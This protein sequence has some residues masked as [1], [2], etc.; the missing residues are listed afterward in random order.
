MI[1]TSFNTQRDK[2]RCCRRKS[3]SLDQNSNSN[4]SSIHSFIHSLHLQAGDLTSQV[5]RKVPKSKTET[6]HDLLHCGHTSTPPSVAWFLSICPKLLK[7]LRETA[8]PSV[9]E[10]VVPHC[11]QMD[12]DEAD[13][14]FLLTHLEG[15]VGDVYPH[16]DTRTA[17]LMVF[18]VH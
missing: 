2:H 10:E 14:D 5:P 11:T 1:Q 12:A 8:P 4:S 9:G 15:Q 13:G 16:W 6:Q 7:S 18:N 3:L 17:A